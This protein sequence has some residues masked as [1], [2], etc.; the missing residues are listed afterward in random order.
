MIVKPSSPPFR[1]VLS[2]GLLCLAGVAQA[3]TYY[4]SPAGSDS[5]PGSL[6]A[7]FATLQKAANVANPGDTIYMRGGTYVLN[8]SAVQIGRSGAS[9]SPITVINYPGE[10]PVLDGINIT[11]SYR[12]AIQL[13]NASWWHIQG[14]EI[15]NAAAMGI[16]I[17]SSSSNITI[18]RCNLHHNVRIQGSGAGIQI[19]STAGGNNLILDNDAHHNGINSVTG[20]MPSSTGGDGIGDSSTAR[21]NVIRGNRVW[22]NADDGIDLWGAYGVLVESNWSWENGKYDDGTL[23]TGNG[24]G[25]KLGGATAGDGAHTVQLNMA[26]SNSHNG[27]DA[28]SA[29]L[30]MNV[31]N[32]TSYNNGG[33]DYHFYYGSVAYV[34]KNNIAYLAGLLPADMGPSTLHSFNSWDLPVTVSGAD[35]VS[36]DYSG[37]AGP[38]SGDGSLPN[39]AFLQLAPGSDLVGKG[40]DVGLP[41]NGSAPDLGAYRLSTLPAP[42]NLEVI[43]Q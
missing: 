1:P 42:T 17:N 6:S 13:D 27:F 10:T 37:A 22:R 43:A 33:S 24:T 4:V 40:V 28:N 5:S 38:R 26:W 3:A 30:P 39:I 34:L 18:E 23:T 2:I 9:G 20:R 14:L 7:P 21:G 29:D 31:Y 35:F 36:L 32:N 19:N 15:K 12:S 16:Y 8:D 11:T 25:F 41:F